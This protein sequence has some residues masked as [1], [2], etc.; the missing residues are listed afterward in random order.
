MKI[1]IIV[2]PEGYENRMDLNHKLLIDRLKQD[3]RFAFVDAQY[4][5]HINIHDY[6]VIINDLWPS[7]N[8]SNLPELKHHQQNVPLIG[9]MF[10]DY[11]PYDLNNEKIGQDFDFLIMRYLNDVTRSDKIF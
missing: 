2:T 6:D 5:G 4:L 10:E 7:Y 8:R 1:L 11:Y 9:K 3:H